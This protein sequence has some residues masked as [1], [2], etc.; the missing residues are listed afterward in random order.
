MNCATKIVKGAGS[1]WPLAFGSF[2]Q[3]LAI[4]GRFGLRKRVLLQLHAFFFHVPEQQA[5]DHSWKGMIGY[6]KRQKVRWNRSQVS[7]RHCHR[8][9]RRRHPRSLPRR[10][11]SSARRCS[12]QP[13]RRFRPRRTRRPR[14]PRLRRRPGSSSRS[15]RSRPRSRLLRPRRIQRAC[16]V[17]T[18]C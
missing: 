15:P 11:R 2:Q 17:W 7:T 1:F 13:C 10:P 3:F 16:R 14:V 5:K 8:R 6:Q 9:L 12:R 4:W 18:W